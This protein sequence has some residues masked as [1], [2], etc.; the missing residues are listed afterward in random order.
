MPQ[1][2]RTHHPKRPNSAPQGLGAKEHRG[3]P[4]SRDDSGPEPD[5]QVDE[6]FTD[7]DAN[8]PRGQREQSH[9][10][11]QGAGQGRGAN[12]GQRHTPDRSR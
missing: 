9:Q 7:Q 3:K 5:G 10:G 12:P 4:H 1:K 2:P 6:R 8:E 11:G